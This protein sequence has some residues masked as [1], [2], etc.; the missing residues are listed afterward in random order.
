M[1]ITRIF[2]DSI[3][4]P[5]QGIL[6]IIKLKRNKRRESCVA[7]LVKYFQE[8]AALPAGLKNLGLPLDPP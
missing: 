2:Y 3:I 5:F 6:I 1:N 8:V 7:D 4:G